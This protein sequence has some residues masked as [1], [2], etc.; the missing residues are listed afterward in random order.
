MAKTKP[1]KPGR[2][3][4]PASMGE[5]VDGRFSHAYV[6]AHDVSQWVHENI[7]RPGGPLHN[8]EHNHLVDADIAFLWAGE[9]YTKQ[10]RRILGMTE[11]VL[12]R[13]GKWQRGRQEQ[14]MTE[15]F[16]RV[17]GWLITLDAGYC[18]HCSDAE[19]CSLVEHE[20]YHVGQERDMF[21]APAFTKDGLPKLAMRGHDV[22]EFIGVVRRYG[23]GQSTGVL[24]KLVS[25][26]NNTPE[27]A[28]VGISQACGTCLA[29][30][31]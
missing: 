22:E 24:A 13:V 17:P 16:G 2:P 7:L 10:M 3:M 26:A 4:P 1:T 25:A 5:F 31:A 21:G 11:E 15:W 12:F 29:R 9:D 14:Q 28:P 23:M 30:A 27:V 19:F 18:A 8:E 6:P 20:L